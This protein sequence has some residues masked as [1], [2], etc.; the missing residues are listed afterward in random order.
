MEIKYIRD[1]LV[2][3]HET[4]AVQSIPVQYFRDQVARENVKIQRSQA[5]IVSLQNHIS[6]IE[7]V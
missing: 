2:V 3:E 1:F 4:G 5:E 7:A 6:K